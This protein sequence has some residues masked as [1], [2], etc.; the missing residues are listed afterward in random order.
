MRALVTGANGF[1]GL[2][3]V[4]HLSSCGDE[5]VGSDTNIL[6][7]EAITATVA[8]ARPDVV[9]H[10]AAQADVGGSWDSPVDTLRVNVEGTLNVCDASRLA[11]TRRVLGVTSADVYG[12]VD[13]SGP[14]R[15]KLNET[16]PLRPTSPYAA[17]K[18]AAE[19]I[20]TQAWLGHGLNVVLARSFNHLGP[21]QSDRFVASAIASRI[22]AN[23]RNGAATVPVGNLEARRDFT[24]VRDVVRAY[25]LLMQHGTPGEVYHV[26]SG[27]DR[28]V[29]QIAEQLVG[30]AAFPMTLELDPDLLRPVDLKVLCGDNTKIRTHTGW[31]PRIPIEATLGDLLEFWRRNPSGVETP[32]HI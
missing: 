24:D 14:D 26:C 15:A 18:A 17:S 12:R 29:R 16:T 4:A 30:L 23:E 22:A 6:D 25:R 10:L 5:V 13:Q 2:H 21:G 31:S 11:G 28:A 20:Y 1:V 9:Y 27:K 19:I 32:Q 3:L 8:A 7:R